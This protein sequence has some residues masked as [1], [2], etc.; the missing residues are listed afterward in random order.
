MN[1]LVFSVG[2]GVMAT[3]F[4]AWNRGRKREMSPKQLILEGIDRSGVLGW[5]FDVN[6]TMEK[7]SQGQVGISRVLGKEPM[8]RYQSRNALDALLGPTFARAQDAQKVVPDAVKR[9]LGDSEAWT[10]GDTRAMRRLLPFQN[11]FYIRQL[12]DKAQSG[13]DDKLG[14]EESGEYA[15]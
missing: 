9:V 3:L 7:V 6:N 12:L 10:E 8:S 14:V 2:L 5:V 4:H 11:L 1:G 13:L 15:E